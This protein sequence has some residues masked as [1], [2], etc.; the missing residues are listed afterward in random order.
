MKI[1]ESTKSDISTV[2]AYFTE[3]AYKALPDPGFG[4]YGQRQ[5]P[6]CDYWSCFNG[7][8]RVGHEREF[9]EKIERENPGKY[10][11]YHIGWSNCDQSLSL[12]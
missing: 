12:I 6:K 9:I 11:Q 1:T 3:E 10:S 7:T 5:K 4:M 2:Y 8:Y